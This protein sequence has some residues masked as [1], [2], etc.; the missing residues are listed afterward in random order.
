MKYLLFTLL[1]SISVTVDAQQLYGTVQSETGEPLVSA[2]VYWEGTTNGTFTND[3]GT[4]KIDR[5][6]TAATLL[7]SYVGYNPVGF[8]IYTHEDTV[9][10]TINGI[11]ELD[12]VQVTEEQDDNYVSTINTLNVEHIN[13]GELRKAP[14]C[15]LSESFET[16]A[17]VDV[18]YN[19][20]I[21]GAKEIQMLGLRGAYTQLLLENR[22]YMGGLGTPYEME[23]IPGTWLESIQLAKGGGS[24]INGYQSI[25]GQINTEIVKP[26]KDNK[27]FVNLFGATSGRAEINV[28][29]N[30][31]INDK[32]STGLLLH[33]SLI[34]NEMDPNQD[35]FIDMP[36]KRHVNGMYRF[37]YRGDVLKAQFNIH[38]LMSKHK[39]GQLSS[40]SDSGI[41]PYQIDQDIKRVNVF[42]KSGY[43]G[44][45]NPNNSIGF[46]L[47]GGWHEQEAIFGEQRHFGIQKQLY[48][49]LIYA[50][51][52]GNTDNRLNVGGS[53]LLDDYDE[54][55][56]DMDLSRRESV[57]GVFAEYTFNRVAPPGADAQ[58]LD[59]FNVIAGLRADYHNLFDL[60]VSPRL[61]MKYDFSKDLVARI[62]AS[63]GYRYANIIAENYNFLATNRAVVVLND[64]EME[65]AWN[66]GANIT[67]KY[68]LGVRPASIALDLYRTEFQNQVVV[69]IE[70]DLEK[71][72][73]YN[74]DGRSIANSFIASSSFEL[75]DGLDLRVAY[76][77]T[78]VQA[79]FLGEWRRRP[80]LARHRGLVSLDYETK[81]KD[82][83]FSTNFQIVG[84]QRLP[85]N[86]GV[87]E[88]LLTDHPE[89]SP[90]YGL[91]SAQVT[92]VFKK[93]ELYVGGE[94]LTNYVQD[95]PI[96]DAA[97]PNSPFF[98][99][100]QVYA[101]TFGIRGYVGLRLMIDN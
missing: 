54:T 9:L 83:R 74:L 89:Q 47:S 43:T 37:F 99:G 29:L 91:L 97:N 42:M 17:A 73:F 53:Y 100:S 49:N 71:I 79:D 5:P 28:H 64:L 61:S 36:L 19:D 72:L 16:N 27:V 38:G 39:A 10:L 34:D 56:D 95:N 58:F 40:L 55:L 96:I 62:S 78:E 1:V 87:P 18:V 67:W 12:E 75:I 13:S 45:K 14:C 82:W 26:F 98:N 85:D 32:V 50:T 3:D 90:S 25:A 92:K 15:N 21:T 24:V 22:P 41:D 65:E 57:P 80:L 84:T 35:G 46:M 8:P 33:G 44:F 2:T 59:R 88:E 52:I 63:K 76:K 30:K 94:N 70:T 77:W 7:V 86:T 48:A 81:D 93:W 4:F 60:L 51:I 68:R 69:D 23:F 66:Y 20:A 101:P 31:P 6:D 11:T